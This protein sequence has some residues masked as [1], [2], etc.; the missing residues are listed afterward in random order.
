M[1]EMDA[2]QESSGMPLEVLDEQLRRM[3]VDPL[4]FQRLPAVSLTGSPQRQQTALRR[5]QQPPNAAAQ[6]ALPVVRLAGTPSASLAPQPAATTSQPA[7][8]AVSLTGGAPRADLPA[9]IEQLKR[10]PQNLFRT[11]VVS[12][13]G[14]PNAQQPSRY[15]GVVPQSPADRGWL[16]SAKL[17]ERSEREKE[18]E[19]G[20]GTQDVVDRGASG[21]PAVRLS[22]SANVGTQLS[23]PQSGDTAGNAMS[24]FAASRA[25]GGVGAPG[26][27]AL[28]PRT[29]EDDYRDLLK[30]EPTRAQFPEQKLPMWRKVLGLVLAGASGQNAGPL[31]EKILHGRERQAEEKFNRA[32]QDWENKASGFMKAAQ[33][34]HTSM[35]DRNLQSEIDARNQPGAEHAK[36]AD[37]YA[38]A[39]RKA[40]Q[41]GRDPLQDPDVKRY[42]DA[43]QNIQR[44]PS[45][46]SRTETP[47][48]VWRQQHPNADV[49]DY[50]KLQPEARSEFRRPKDQP[51]L[52]P[53]QKANLTRRYK[54]SLAGIEE[55]FRAR[56][57]GTYVDK[58]SG[59]LLPPMT[60]DEL[61]RRK[62]DAEDSYKDE[63]EAAG[64]TVTRY[65]Y[66][67]ENGNA[68]AAQNA[69]SPGAQ[70][71]VGDE[72]TY[73]GQRYRIAGIKNG[74]AQLA[75][76][77]SN[78]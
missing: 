9:P 69:P 5:P 34:H 45:G 10:D 70:H 59:E 32:H 17:R 61:N 46:G 1:A 58:R 37:L 3:G 63:L 36:L 7:T 66:G 21:T 42:S 2:L 56:Q 76:L 60:Q 52:T 71:Q 62:Q 74:K 33:L 35:E 72:V 27:S 53:G 54:D 39:V 41:E 31:A 23:A 51:Q 77:G 75:P 4:M 65:R 24:M 12:L 22:E 40:A 55:E 26:T 20:A 30:E 8:P 57:S 67:S 44:E 43:I 14:Q 47:F 48:S 78:Q 50:F 25:N 49:S 28:Q 73:K 68:G 15:D 38:D 64:E 29:T 19:R 11:P 16:E 6:A 18:A 13:T